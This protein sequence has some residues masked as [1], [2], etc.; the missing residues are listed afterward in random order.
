MKYIYTTTNTISSP[1]ALRV[2]LGPVKKELSHM[3]PPF[4]HPR[5]PHVRWYTP[6]WGDT[7]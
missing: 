6:L 3:R 2:L 4:P 5:G 7:L 1:I